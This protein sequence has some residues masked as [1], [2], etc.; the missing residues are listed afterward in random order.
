MESAELT[1]RV[2]FV[3]YEVAN[4]T[5][6]YMIKVSTSNNETFHIKDRYKCMRTLYD[7]LRG[8]R[9]TVSR[10]PEF[11][12]KKW[13][14]N[15][16]TDFILQRQDQLS[17]FFNT[18]LEQPGLSTNSNILG[19]FKRKG[20]S[21]E[22][23]DT[24]ERIRSYINDG[25]SIIESN[26]GGQPKSQPDSGLIKKSEEEKQPGAK[27]GAAPGGNSSQADK[28]KMAQMSREIEKD[29]KE[30]CSKIVAGVSEKMIDLGYSG[31]GEV[32]EIMDKL[33]KY[34]TEFNQSK[35]NDEFRFNT[36]LLD[37][38]KGEEAAVEDSDEELDDLMENKLD[39]IQAIL[40]KDQRE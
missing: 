18:L 3:N 29:F 25:P 35:I 23:K 34:S 21:A 30:N 38:P 40:F 26:K 17:N 2:Q 36:N 33:E 19:Y 13:F 4:G 28:Q 11:P 27:R 32:Q 12:G 16:N 8:D 31:M 15:T 22:D 24:V 20:Q 14:G 37:V 1:F 9:A 10:M 7:S 6:Y 39:S 5:V